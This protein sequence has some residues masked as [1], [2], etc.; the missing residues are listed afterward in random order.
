MKEIDFNDAHALWKFGCETVNLAEQ[1]QQSREAFAKA[2]LLF[3]KELAK[4]Y[5]EDSISSGMAEAKAF[6]KLSNLSNELAKALETYTLKEQEYK[7]LEKVVDTRNGLLKFNASI[8]A[9]Q[10]KEK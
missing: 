6:V 8:I 1:A 7:G 3:R 2:T 4:A 10:P 5:G 9:N